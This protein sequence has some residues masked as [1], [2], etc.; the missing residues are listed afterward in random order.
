MET[1]SRPP[2]LLPALRASA[3]QMPLHSLESFVR[4]TLVDE[5]LAKSQG[6]VRGAAKLL[7]ISRQLLQH[8][9]NARK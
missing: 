4:D 8:I 5:A 6:S 9:L 3:G 2:D 7:R 1:L